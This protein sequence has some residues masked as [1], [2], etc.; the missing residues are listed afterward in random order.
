M[1]NGDFPIAML[2]YQRV[3]IEPGQLK[4]RWCSKATLVYEKILGDR[5]GVQRGYKGGM[6]VINHGGGDGFVMVI[7]CGHDG[8]TMGAYMS[9]Y[10]N[11]YM[12]NGD[13]WSRAHNATNHPQ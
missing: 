1:N 3:T 8:D 13:R 5:R 10:R 11:I 6:T 7:W 2:V 12:I 9:A 4:K